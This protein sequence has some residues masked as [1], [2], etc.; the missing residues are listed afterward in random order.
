MRNWLQLHYLH[1]IHESFKSTDTDPKCRISRIGCDQFQFRL[2]YYLCW[3]TCV[4][5][6]TNSET[7]KQ[8]SY[9]KISD[10]QYHDD[11]EENISGGPSRMMR[12]LLKKMGGAQQ[13]SELRNQIRLNNLLQEVSYIIQWQSDS[14]ESSW[15]TYLGKTRYSWRRDIVRRFR[16]LVI[17]I[18]S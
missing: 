15:C 4:L 10:L 18:P 6:W 5:I 9:M 2:S 16:A 11:E 14:I 17:H 8:R 3:V 13:D 7:S 1:R 12:S